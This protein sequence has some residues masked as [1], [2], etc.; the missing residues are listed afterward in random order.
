[1]ELKQTELEQSKQDRST[2]PPLNGNDRR[3]EIRRRAYEIFEERGTR[4]GSEME[5]WL[6][7]EAELA[8]AEFLAPDDADFD[9]RGEID[10][11][12]KPGR[13]AA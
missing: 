13:K 1:M 12:V 11:A 8:D 4:P 10:V 6:Q 9:E 7:A 5:D 3:E 2:P